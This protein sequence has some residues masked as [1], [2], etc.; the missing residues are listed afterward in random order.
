MT[1]KR[2]FIT[3]AAGGFGRALAERFA[4]GGFDVLL[5]DLD[6]AAGAVA[7]QEISAVAAGVRV[8][9]LHCDV[10]SEAD[11]QRAADW[12][13]ENWGGVDLLINNA[14]VAISG[15][16][17]EC[18]EADWDWIVQ[19]NLVGVA[20]GCRIFTPIMKAQ[21]SGHIVNIASLA[22][23]IHAPTMSA[24]NATKAAVV[25]ISETLAV[26][27]M[28]FGIDVSVVCPSFFRT[29]IAAAARPSS[30]EID[31]LTRKLVEKSRHSA[32]EI[33]AIVFDDVMRKRFRIQT[34]TEGKAAYAL[35][36]IL[37]FGLYRS[38]IHRS[39]AKMSR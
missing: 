19:I 13:Q 22:G 26:E 31:R 37:P 32:D 7:A 2:A 4:R 17:D 9:Y 15:P 6:D 10:T 27:L 33:A 16:I 3:G 14:G 8:H 34:H 18:S 23:L 38:M 39:T 12:M 30:P 20:R 36:R 5:G 21:G 25:A 1:S 24:Y 29:G 35:K 11:V 28:P